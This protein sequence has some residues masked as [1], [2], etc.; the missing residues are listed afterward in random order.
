M[1]CRG[2]DSRKRIVDKYNLN[3][4]AH[5]Q[6][7]AGQDKLSCTNI[8][9]TDT[10]YCFSY[11]AKEEK[12]SGSFFCGSYAAN[13]FLELTGLDPLPLFNPLVAQNSGRS[14]G[15]GGNPQQGRQAW[16][17]T[18]KQLYNAINLLVVSWD[19]APG[20]VIAKIKDKVS[21]NYHRAP[22]DSEIK[23]INTIISKDPR[24]RNL[25]EMIDELRNRNNIR[26]FNFDLLNTVLESKDIQSNY[27]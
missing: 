16:D 4:V 9:L 19:I 1:Q 22:Y 13:H 24:G 17:D 26:I 12:D 15:H 27:G 7:L 21:S 8:T 10:Y 20:G 11:E 23:A 5:V 14:G 6:L 2:E 25:Q 3:T 18:A